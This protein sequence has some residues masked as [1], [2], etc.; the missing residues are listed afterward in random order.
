[1][2][3]SEQPVMELTA[4][5]DFFHEVRQIVRLEAGIDYLLNCGRGAVRD[6]V[7]DLPVQPFQRL[8]GFGVFLVGR[9]FLL[10]P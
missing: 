5:S 2:V 7:I 3:V 10:P 1:M 4:A 6:D 9:Q 8:P